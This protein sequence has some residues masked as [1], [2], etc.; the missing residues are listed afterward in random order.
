MRSR[1]PHRHPAISQ[2][3]TCPIS[4]R[5]NLKSITG[6]AIILPPA[7]DHNTQYEELKNRRWANLS[8]PSDMDQDPYPQIAPPSATRD[9]YIY[10]G[11]LSTSSLGA[12]WCRGV[13][14]HWYHNFN[15]N[16]LVQ[17]VER[18]R[19]EMAEIAESVTDSDSGAEFTPTV[20]I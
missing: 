5:H 18:R 8:P 13:F 3:A 9:A 11:D 7:S 19:S 17:D 2:P 20:V 16:T 4:P 14:L 1:S 6:P 10:R 15:P 12:R